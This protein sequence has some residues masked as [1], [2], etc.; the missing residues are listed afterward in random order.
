MKPSGPI[1][2]T[3]PKDQFATLGEDG[4]MSP[5]E[6]PNTDRTVQIAW[7]DMSYGPNSLGFYDGIAETPDSGRRFWWSSP[8]GRGF[9]QLSAGSIGAWRERQTPAEWVDLPS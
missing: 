9:R 1:P 6:P 2:N 4:W 5:T 8:A 3:P 7:D